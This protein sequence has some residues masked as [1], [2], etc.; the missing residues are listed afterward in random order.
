MLVSKGNWI[1][2][3]FL[4]LYLKAYFIGFGSGACW[5]YGSFSDCFTL[6]ISV[7]LSFSWWFH[8]YGCGFILCCSNPKFYP[9]F[10]N[11]FP[12]L[13]LLHYRVF[14]SFDRIVG[15]NFVMLFFS[16][17]R[18]HGISRDFT[19]PYTQEQNGNC[20]RMNRNIMKRARSMIHDAGISFKF[21]PLASYVICPCNIL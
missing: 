4:V 20:E 5:C 13:L 6:W 1:A 7:L 3:L 2:R 18:Q 15:E 16:F 12:I 11:L 21:W 17:C 8:Q 19:I 14:V 10:N 9:S